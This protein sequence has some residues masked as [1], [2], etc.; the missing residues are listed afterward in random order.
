ML[1]VYI[2]VSV[3]TY[4][5]VMTPYDTFPSPLRR[6]TANPHAVSHVSRSGTYKIIHT[7]ALYTRMFPQCGE[8][9]LRGRYGHRGNRI[10][11]LSDTPRRRAHT[12]MYI[13]LRQTR[14][15][16][17]YK[18]TIP[19]IIINNNTRGNRHFSPIALCACI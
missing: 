18:C 17:H 1:Y 3:L 2:D 15:T 8:P 9:R 16:Q 19:F 13:Y 10:R 11:V 6:S 4:S 5:C 12:N 14:R 7:R